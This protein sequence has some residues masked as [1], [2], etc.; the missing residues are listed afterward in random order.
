MALTRK[1]E[2]RRE[3]LLDAVLRVLARDGASG[4]THRAVAAEAGVPL[5]AATYYFSSIDELYVSALRRA[6]EQQLALFEGL[7]GADLG[8]FAAAVHDWAHRDR[9]AAI[10]QY[11]LM[12]EAMRRDALRADAEAWYGALARAIDPEGRHPQ[13]TRVTALAVDGLLL[14]MLWLGDPATVDGVEAAL[15]EIVSR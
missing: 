13:R 7:R 8:A 10:A 9:G 15:R 14:R 11:L 5:S 2:A 3:A 1:G 4:V 12:F 6:T